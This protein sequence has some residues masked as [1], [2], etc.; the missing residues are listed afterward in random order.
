MGKPYLQ[1]APVNVG[2]Y[3]TDGDDELQSSDDE[4]TTFNPSNPHRYLPISHGTTT[5]FGK[6]SGPILIQTAVE[7]KKEFHNPHGQGASSIGEDVHPEECFPSRRRPEFWHFE[8]VN[9]P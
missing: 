7:M 2:D 5:S 3:T 6:S 4:F 1:S 8:P 9:L